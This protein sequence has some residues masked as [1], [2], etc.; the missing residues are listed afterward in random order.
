MKFFR[1][2]VGRYPSNL[3]DLRKAPA[4]L[5]N[6]EKWKGP[7]AE[8]DL[9]PDPWGRPYQLEADGQFYTIKSLGPDIND[10]S[11]DITVSNK[12]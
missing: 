7:Y 6:P 4:D 5:A 1:M 3:E 11:D 10:A 8:K 9:P 2:D 12:S